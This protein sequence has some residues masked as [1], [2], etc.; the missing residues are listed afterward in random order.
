MR[1]AGSADEVLAIMKEEVLKKIFDRKL[2]A[3]IRG[4]DKQYIVQ[5]AQALLDGGVSFMEVTFA[6]GSPAGIRNTLDSIRTLEQ[7]FG[8]SIG[9]GAGTVLTA[10]Q[11]DMAFDNGAKYMISPN[12]NEQ[13]IRRCT[14]LGAVSI[15]GALSPT[16]IADAYDKGA[17]IVKIFPAGEMGAPYIK[18]VRAPLSHIPMMAVGGVNEKNVTEFLNDGM[19]CV[20]IGSALVNQ[21]LIH[22]GEFK[23]ITNL[24]RR[25]SEQLHIVAER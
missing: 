2:I 15:P 22:E 4:V 18:A 7:E 20:G 14:A 11:V 8:Q 21:T 6:Q 5:L 23:Q 12:T 16:E 19:S 9:I 1:L 13:V 17:D 10:D 24:A 3:I 25:Y